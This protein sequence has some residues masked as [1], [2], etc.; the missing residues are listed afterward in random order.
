MSFLRKALFSVFLVL[1]FLIALLASIDNSD[2]V[3]LQFL[4]WRSPV[5]PL[6]WWMLLAF[7]LGMF[8][9]VAL[10]FYRN[11]R[12]RFDV[13]NANKI[14]VDRTRQLDQ[15]RAETDGAGKGVG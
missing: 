4:S 12:L 8:L 7:V 5:W 9:G 15:I 14:A 13:R 6:S 3:A 10:S 1:F 11:A 2:A